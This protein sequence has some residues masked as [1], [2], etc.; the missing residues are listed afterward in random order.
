MS[1]S[2][3][4]KLKRSAQIY[5]KTDQIDGETDLKPRKASSVSSH[6]IQSDFSNICKLLLHI[7]LKVQKL[8]EC[9]GVIGW[10]D[11]S[12]EEP[13]LL[14]N[15]L[16][17]GMKL[18]N[19]QVTGLVVAVGSDT[20]LQKNSMGSARL[21]TT[22]LDSRAN[23][24]C[25]LIFVMMMTLAV[26][27]AAFQG[28]RNYFVNIV[29]FVVLLSFMIPISLKMFL[30]IARVGY[31]KQILGDEE[32][33]GVVVK[34]PNIIDDLG[35]VDIVL[36]DKTGTLTKNE[37]NM[38]KV[39]VKNHL[40][41]ARDFS[42]EYPLALAMVVCSGVNIRNQDGTQIVETSSP[43]E[44]AMVQFFEHLGPKVLHKNEQSIA[45]E[46]SS[47][48]RVEY[49][50]F[51]LFPFES[52]KKK[53]GIIVRRSG[54]EGLEF[55]VKGADSVVRQRLNSE[56]DRLEMD[57][58]VESMSREGLRTLAFARKQ[59]TPSQ[60]AEFNQKYRDN[61]LAGKPLANERLLEL[62]E[63]DMEY[64]GVTGM[65]DQLQE[66]VALAVE[67]IRQAKV[68]FW[69]LTGDK[70]ETAVNVCLS[71]GLLA[72]GR[73]PFLCPKNVT[74]A[75]S[76]VTRD[77]SELLVVDGVVLERQLATNGE[78]FAR[79]MRGFSIVCF[80]RCSPVQKSTIASLLR[81][82]GLRVLA[83]GDGGNDVGMI[84]LADVG[85]GLQGKEG[86][87]A[88][89]AA[90]FSLQRFEN[91]PKLVCF[92]GRNARHGCAAIC[93]FVLH[94]GLIISWIQQ[95]FCQ[96]FSM[97]PV[98]I[99]NGLMMVTYSAVFTVL[100]VLSVILDVEIPWKIL[101]DYLSLYRGSSGVSTKEF[102]IWTMIGVYQAA[103]IVLVSFWI[104]E[105]FLS[106]YVCI[107]FTALILAE[108]L[109]IVFL[110]SKCSKMLGVTLLVTLLLYVVC[111]IV[112]RSQFEVP[113]F[114]FK[115]WKRV[116]VVFS[117]A[118]VPVW[119]LILLFTRVTYPKVTKS[120]R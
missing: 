112:F 2:N 106:K 38:T 22:F 10:E 31:S 120:L 46:M 88:A 101:K 78:N 53:M 93:Q 37:M 68:K 23:F 13:L 32:L 55:W 41:D 100:P 80:A 86:N 75:M 77:A 27:D 105:D 21:K 19:G 48:E 43:D 52:A 58:R 30:L 12:S 102:L 39:A 26:L 97:L 85:V 56:E 9:S 91:L 66:N 45:I 116:L 92:H 98:P 82:A 4:S 99:F 24:F 20:R 114:E 35:M 28:G 118:W 111:A 54:E 49:I 34:T 104:F 14:E 29:R 67:Q 70:L 5:V 83:I 108:S 79:F 3:R 16:W 94:R 65:R 76:R 51:R 74:E 59:L 40:F 109:N 73:A 64:L 72:G 7:N 95:L 110:V 36:S 50:V 87:Q 15:T 71:I 25:M 113:L 47:G 1:S 115:F 63:T 33:E 89:L 60:F 11:S 84:Q 61:E 18:V 8:S 42:L 57:E 90:D 119:A 81:D 44:M 62:L 107:I 117:V 96:M 6:R 103:A 17:S 69:L